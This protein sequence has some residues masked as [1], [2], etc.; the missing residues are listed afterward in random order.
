MQLIHVLV[1][2]Y[3]STFL[4]VFDGII[5]QLIVIISGLPVVEFI[6]NYDETFVLAITYVLVILPLT[7]FIA[8]KLWF[9]INNILKAL[10]DCKV[11][12]FH[13]YSALPTDDAEQ[14]IGPN[15]D[16]HYCR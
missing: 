3:T 8:M 16:R 2:P 15:K 10:K 7:A 5:S 11:K 12:Y 1:Q 6:N 9:N 14:P 4:N 13:R